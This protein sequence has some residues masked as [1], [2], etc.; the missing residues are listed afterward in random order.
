MS[1][2]QI[3]CGDATGNLVSLKDYLLVQYKLLGVLQQSNIDSCEVLIASD[4][5]HF[6]RDLVQVTEYIMNAKQC[7]GL[8]Q[9]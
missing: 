8:Q 5:L 7:L 9:R 6:Q 4:I 2:G 3:T 1:P